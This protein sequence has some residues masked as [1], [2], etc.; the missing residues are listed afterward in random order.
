M[1]HTSVL[2]IVINSVAGGAFLGFLVF[3]LL[4]AT[5]SNWRSTPAGRS[6][7]Y[8]IGSL[9]LVVLM[10]TVHLFT[11]PYPGV[12][13]VRVFVYSVLFLAAW[14]LVGTLVSVLRNGGEVTLRTFYEPKPP[15]GD[16]SNT[17]QKE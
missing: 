3:M 2:D 7:M 5:F 6:L 4:Y 12:E 9:N 1:R 14:R 17:E 11:G 15:K 10:A 16:S 8:A 13:F